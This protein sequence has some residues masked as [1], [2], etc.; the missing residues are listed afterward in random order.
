MGSVHGGHEATAQWGRAQWLCPVRMSSKW[1]LSSAPAGILSFQLHR[2]K[3]KRKSNIGSMWWE[4]FCGFIGFCDVFPSASSHFHH[5]SFDKPTVHYL[6]STKLQSKHWLVMSLLND[7]AKGF[8]HSQKHSAVACSCPKLDKNI[9]ST[10]Q[11]HT[12]FRKLCK[13]CVFTNNTSNCTVNTCS[14]ICFYN[15][16]ASNFAKLWSIFMDPYPF[17]SYHSKM[18]RFIKLQQSFIKNK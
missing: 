13:A 7:G 14:W 5:R 4:G 18:Q 11:L 9:S 8:L 1:P 3:R 12:D 17:I 2:E 15:C 10:Q 6:P 16:L